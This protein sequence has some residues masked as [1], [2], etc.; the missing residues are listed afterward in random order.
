[1]QFACPT[2]VDVLVRARTTLL[3][4]LTGL[5]LVGCATIRLDGN[6]DVC[7][8]P[9]GEGMRASDP[10]S[11]VTDN[12]SVLVRTLQPPARGQAQ[13]FPGL[14]EASVARPSTSRISD[15]ITSDDIVR[16]HAFVTE[17][18]RRQL[19]ARLANPADASAT[20]T[21]SLLPWLYEVPGPEFAL[22]QR[23]REANEAREQLNALWGRSPGLSSKARS[24]RRTDRA[25]P[26]QIDE[27]F[28]TFSRE[29]AEVVRRLGQTLIAGG[30]DALVLG[31]AG[32]LS[33]LLDTSGKSLYAL[34]DEE[35][36]AQQL[37]QQ[38][39]TSRF[40]SV[41]ARAYFRGGHLFQASLDLDDL[42]KGFGDRIK[43]SLPNLTDA[44]KQV[45]DN[46]LK[47][48]FKR[49][50]SSG[51]DITQCLLSKPLGKESFVT[52][53]GQ[54]V[55]FSGVTLTF[56]D[57]GRLSPTLQYPKGE[58]LASQLVRVFFEAIYDSHGIIVP[59]V[60]SSTVCVEK[61]WPSEFCLH[62]VPS[63][64]AGAKTATPTKSQRVAWVDSYANQVE[65]VVTAATAELIR[66]G[67]WVALNNEAV[68]RAVETT[69]GVNSRKIAEKVL[70]NLQTQCGEQA[71]IVNPGAVR[72]S[73]R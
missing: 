34:A 4:A 13:I 59:A 42:V 18:L 69:A 1:M 24:I 43:A 58:E 55:Q 63:A 20:D 41:Y 7:S 56:G 66:G 32:K 29:D 67:A 25:G 54:T 15:E 50:C 65:A 16:G 3:T 51:Q 2:V 12:L 49:G 73:V 23:S 68:A 44:Q 47:N 19:A 53:A 45:L 10:S 27:S 52:R 30:Y 6:I 61:L 46:E 9:S 26:Y 39:N 17:Q 11:A 64:E 57:Q 62:D 28:G 33:L 40:I 38:L 21:P 37:L 14:A 72:I 70:W 22:R 5:A 31:T 35:V 71:G 8:A 60:S 36:R 48:L